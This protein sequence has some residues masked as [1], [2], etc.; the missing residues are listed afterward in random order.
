M[1]K[2]ICAGGGGLLLE[3]VLHVAGGVLQVLDAV[4]DRGLG[5]V[6]LA[7]AL[8]LLVVG[9]LA[10]GLLDLALDVRDLVGGLVLGTHRGV[11]SLTVLCSLREPISG[12][13][14]HV[15]LIASRYAAEREPRL[16]GVS[17]LT[18]C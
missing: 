10:C 18:R 11:L 5:L 16:S 4:L 6:A 12:V 7:L 2:C 14:M 13:P 9:G 15:T 3:G 1:D 17:A 8:E